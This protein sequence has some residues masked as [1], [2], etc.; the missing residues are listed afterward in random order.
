MKARRTRTSRSQ[1]PKRCPGQ[2]DQEIGQHITFAAG[3]MPI[4]HV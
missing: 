2:I 1:R 3:A 4:D